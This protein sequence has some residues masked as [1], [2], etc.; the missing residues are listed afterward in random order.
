M[1][2]DAAR[3][4]D[5]MRIRAALDERAAALRAKDASQVTL[6]LAP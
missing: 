2:V 5:E 1:T 4:D 6:M 3:V